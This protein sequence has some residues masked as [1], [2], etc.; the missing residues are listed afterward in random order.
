MKNIL[1]F[2]GTFTGAVIGLMFIQPS[3][4]A[5]TLKGNFDWEVQPPKTEI[6]KGNASFML[7]KEKKTGMITFEITMVPTPNPSPNTPVGTKRKFNITDA[8][9]DEKWQLN[10]FDFSGNGAS[11]M[12]NFAMPNNTNAAGDAQEAFKSV[13]VQS[14]GERIPLIISKV[15]IKHVPEPSS[16]LGLLTLCSLGAGSSFLRKQKQKKLMGL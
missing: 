7:D 2:G 8:D 11:G 6:F 16:T 15:D 1:K 12:I 9:L 4:L 14:D 10:K 13:F 3:V 5:A